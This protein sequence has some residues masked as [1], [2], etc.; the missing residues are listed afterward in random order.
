LDEA[1]ERYVED[2]G[3]LFDQLGG[4]PMMGRVLGALLLADPPELAAEELADRLRASRSSVSQATHSLVQ[5]G[6][7]ER[8][9]RPGERRSYF[10]VKPGAWHVMLR[11]RIEGL[12]VLREMAESGL[13]VLGSEEPEARHNLQEMRD[14]FVAWERVVPEIF[15]RIEQEMKEEP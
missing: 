15:E 11:R 8:R 5:M 13:E 14:F 6:L 10:R 9:R 3:V 1:K 12:R 4:G 2:F 7:I